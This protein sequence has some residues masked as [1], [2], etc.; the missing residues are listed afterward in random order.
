[1]TPYI[2]G[3]KDSRSTSDGS[4]SVRMTLRFSGKSI[5]PSNL[6]A[7]FLDIIEGSY[8]TFMLDIDNPTNMYIRKAEENE[9]WTS[10]VSLRDSK[11][12][13]LGMSAM[14]V[15]NH[16]RVITSAKKSVTC[17]VSPKPTIV[18]GK[19]YYRIITEKP[20]AKN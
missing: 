10:K 14:A 20:Y 4:S 19:R 18:D 15:A 5:Y 9:E 17:Y 11:K 12:M 6:L 2:F 7:D 1:M 3:N 13:K 16:V 8:V